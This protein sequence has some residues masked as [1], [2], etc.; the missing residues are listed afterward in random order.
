[1]S[2]STAG[3][4]DFGAEYEIARLPRELTTAVSWYMDEHGITKREL[5]RRLKVTPGRVSQILSGDENLTL[6]T[7]A[8]VCAALDVHLQVELVGNKPADPA[9]R[10]FTHGT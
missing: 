2:A 8:A 6:R 7:M 3:E 5:A 9:H 4:V 10:Q 1:M